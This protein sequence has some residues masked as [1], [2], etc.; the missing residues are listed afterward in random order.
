M[1]APRARVRFECDMLIAREMRADVKGGERKCRWRPL[2]SW[3]SEA[4]DGDQDDYDAM[5]SQS[6]DV[7]DA[8]YGDPVFVVRPRGSDEGPLREGWWARAGK[9]YSRSAAKNKESGTT[10]VVTRQKSAVKAEE[11]VLSFSRVSTVWPALPQVHWM[12][13]D[14][15]WEVIRQPHGA[16]GKSGD[17]RGIFGLKTKLSLIHI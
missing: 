10:G 11:L 13:Q 2:R 16:T 7:S 9:W 4:G 17:V 3:S 5:L 8:K 6:W 1:D 14:D 15:Q 12:R